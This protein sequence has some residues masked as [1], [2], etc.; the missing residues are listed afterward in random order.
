MW[1][2]INLIFPVVNSEM[3]VM[4]IDDLDSDT[5]PETISN[6]GR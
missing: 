2:I 6:A 4:G 5:H 1:F 3:A